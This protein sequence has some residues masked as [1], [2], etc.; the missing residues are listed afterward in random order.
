M[1]G[2]A[3]VMGRKGIALSVA[4]SFISVTERQKAWTHEHVHEEAGGIL[5]SY[6]R[7]A[8]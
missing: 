1:L 4:P 7:E 2:A 3:V 8:R 6:I 5:D